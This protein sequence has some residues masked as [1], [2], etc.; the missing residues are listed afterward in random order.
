MLQ[1][2]FHGDKRG[3]AI[4]EISVWRSSRKYKRVETRIEAWP[5]NSPEAKIIYIY[6][7]M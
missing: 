5:Q 6:I 1:W 2:Y 7:Y 3:C 4:S